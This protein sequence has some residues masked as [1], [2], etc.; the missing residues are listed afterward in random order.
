MP[1]QGE[2]ASALAVRL[3]VTNNLSS[4][5]DRK[6][7]NDRI[8]VAS[9]DLADEVSTDSDSDSPSESDT[10]APQKVGSASESSSTAIPSISELMHAR[11]QIARFESSAV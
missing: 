11:E 6:N 1:L 3:C 10:D 8:A 4:R 2:Y 5:G 7:F 9:F